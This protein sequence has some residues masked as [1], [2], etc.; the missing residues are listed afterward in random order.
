MG[1]PRKVGKR[2]PTLK[3]RLDAPETTWQPITIEGWY[4]K[5]LPTFVDALA[6]VRQGLW[7]S[8]LFSSSRST[9]D[10][11]KIPKALLD[12]WFSLLCYAA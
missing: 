12:C 4:S 2:L 9:T 3:A 5:S 10:V 6:L 11:V 8:R 7:Q 1:R